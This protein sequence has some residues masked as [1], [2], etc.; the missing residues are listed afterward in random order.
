MFEFIPL[1]R[2]QK[3]VVL[4]QMRLPLVLNDRNSINFVDVH[5]VGKPDFYILNVVG[6]FS[7]GFVAVD[8]EGFLIFAVDVAKSARYRA[9]V[10][11]LN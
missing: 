4:L 11:D 9:V 1:S 10:E 7:K 8:W 5:V 2:V 6:F 3:Y